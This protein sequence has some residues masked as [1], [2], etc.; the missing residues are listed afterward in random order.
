MLIGI[1]AKSQAFFLGAVLFYLEA[2]NVC[3]VSKTDSDEPI[4]RNM[5]PSD[6]SGISDSYDNVSF[7]Y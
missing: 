3:V 7:Q 4:P 6:L 2:D 1:L 5:L